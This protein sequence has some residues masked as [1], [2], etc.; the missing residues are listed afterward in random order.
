MKRRT[1]IFVT[2]VLGA[3]LPMVVAIAAG[4]QGSRVPRACCM[5]LV[6]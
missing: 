4:E 2:V 5:E 6:E 1:L 3:M